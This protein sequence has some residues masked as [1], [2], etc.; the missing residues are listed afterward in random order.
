MV[1][2][3]H[4]ISFFIGSITSLKSVPKVHSSN[5]VV[6][7]TIE[8]GRNFSMRVFDIEVTMCGSKQVALANITSASLA[9][10]VLVKKSSFK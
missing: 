2:G 7:I 5:F 10:A 4:D 3:P 6:I 9:Q 8:P 1:A